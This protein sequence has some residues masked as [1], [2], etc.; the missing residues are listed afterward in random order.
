[1]PA[2]S[3][4]HD[5]RRYSHWGRPFRRQLSPQAQD[6]FPRD[7]LASSGRCRYEGCLRFEWRNGARYCRDH[8]LLVYH[9]SSLP[10]RL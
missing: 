1:M 8:W 7:A 2:C 9:Q 10:D 4:K 3:D 6:G 5:A